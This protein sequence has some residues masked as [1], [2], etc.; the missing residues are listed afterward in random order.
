M[1]R[2]HIWDHGITEL[3]H[4]ESDVMRVLPVE[5]GV[6]VELDSRKAYFVDVDA[7]TPPKPILPPAPRDPLA[8]ADGRTVVQSLGGTLTV[9]ELPSCARWTLPTRYDPEATLTVSA[10][11]R[12]VGQGAGD[13]IALWHL[14]RSDRELAPWLD[15]LTN[16]TANDGLLVWPWQVTPVNP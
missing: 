11:S 6:V 12:V 4:F 5:G 16:A 8:S 14:P 2:T 1:T 10:T 7:R 15:E 9:V 3:A 13:S